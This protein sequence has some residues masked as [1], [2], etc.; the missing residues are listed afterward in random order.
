MIHT[1]LNHRP[2]KKQMKVSISKPWLVDLVVT[3]DFFQK[4]RSEIR[5]SLQRNSKNLERLYKK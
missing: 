1:G 5:G 2:G 3:V 4:P